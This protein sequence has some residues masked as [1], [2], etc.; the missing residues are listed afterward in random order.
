MVLSEERRGESWYCLYLFIYVTPREAGLLYL[1]EGSSKVTKVGQCPVGDM[2]AIQREPIS[3]S[4][5]RLCCDP[6]GVT[7]NLMAPA[8]RVLNVT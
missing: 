2:A 6:F 1:M 8:R 7:L 3:C 5:H 4:H